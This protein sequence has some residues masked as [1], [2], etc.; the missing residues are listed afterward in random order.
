MRG[1][2]KTLEGIVAD[3]MVI[4]SGEGDVVARK[5]D[6]L[7]RVDQMAGGGGG[8][9][10]KPTVTL[11]KVEV[12]LF[13][14][15]A[16]VSSKVTFKMEMNGKTNSS[17][18]NQVNTYTRDKD[19]WKL[20]S[21]QVSEP[22]AVEYS[23]GDV[24]Y[25]VTIDPAAMKGT[26]DADVVMIEF[27]DYEC[28]LC[29]RFADETMDRLRKDYVETGRVGMIARNFPLEKLLP[30]AFG[31]AKAAHCAAEQGKFWEMHDRM[32]RGTLALAP[33][34]LK[35][36]A[37]SLGLDQDK[38]TRCVDDVQTTEAIRQD[39]KFGSQFGITGTPYFL[40]GV[41]KPNSSEVKAVR[42]IKGAY[43]YEVFKGAL[44]SVL[45]AHAQ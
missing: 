42:L 22:A 14:P 20:V 24:R 34:D 15:T 23:A 43:P 7:N 25:D 12:F 28:P 9:G 18:S 32:L 19:T 16:V 37:R 6:F 31:A 4:F 26:K 36:H 10:P 38:F 27:V 17:V 2:R 35:E 13:G 33:A 5:D 3:D 40:I 29:R 41:R 1:D 44:D 45:T 11:D 8:G 39:K 21:S 30:L